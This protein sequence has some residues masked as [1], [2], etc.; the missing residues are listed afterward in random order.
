MAFRNKGRKSKKK[1]KQFLELK[2]DGLLHGPEAVG[3]VNNRAIFVPRAVPGDELKVQVTEKKKTFWRADIVN[4]LNPSPH[5]R[6][7]PCHVFGRCGGCQWLHIDYDQQVEAKVSN[8]LQTLKRIGRVEVDKELLVEP[9]KSPR[10]YHYRH[11]ARLRCRVVAPGTLAV[12]FRAAGSHRV[13]SHDECWIYNPTI[14]RALFTAGRKMGRE[15]LNTTFTCHGAHGVGDKAVTALC[16]EVREEELVEPIAKAF[17]AACAHLPL[18]YEVKA[19]HSDKCLKS[20]EAA[21]ISYEVPAA[22]G[23]TMTLQAHA[24]SF[25]QANLDSNAELV[26]TLLQWIDLQEE[27]SVLDLYSGVGNL[28]I[29]LL[30]KA[31]A[32]YAIEQDAGCVVQ[33]R[34]NA[35]SYADKYK[36]LEGAAEEVI[37]E[38][39]SQKK[40]FDTIIL[41][42]PR[43]GARPLLPAISELGA[44][45]IIY[46]S[47]DPATLARDIGALVEDGKYSVSRLRV[48]DLFP[49][50]FHS[51]TMVELKLS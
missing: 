50:T 44:K 31:K 36:I 11:R 9:F 6:K 12:G 43:E 39:K 7:P 32:V 24:R 5:R 22:D 29:P 42:P 18:R 10:K 34:S 47:C 16:I 26:K 23:K 8:V 49:Q 33:A 51:E 45:K 38:L 2:I 14:R 28:S 3:R 35:G 41:D 13:I 20:E 21:V 4:V 46:V 48:F 17:A 30:P 15:L 27:D 1:K 37:E 40:S 25:F 19:A